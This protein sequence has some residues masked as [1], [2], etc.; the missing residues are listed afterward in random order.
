MVTAMQRKALTRAVL[1]SSAAPPKQ[2]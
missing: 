2:P 1:A